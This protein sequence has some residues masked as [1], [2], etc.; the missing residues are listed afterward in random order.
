V[1]A[2]LATK[3]LARLKPHNDDQKVRIALSSGTGFTIVARVLLRKLNGSRGQELDHR[4]DNG[5]AKS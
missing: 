3:A 1:A 4:G 5:E 2:L